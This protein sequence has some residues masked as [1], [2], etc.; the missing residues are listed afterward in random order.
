M[1]LKD[2]FNSRSKKRELSSKTLTSGDDPNK[3]RDGSFNMDDVFRKVYLLLILLRFYVTVL[4]MLRSKYKEFTVK[5][6][7]QK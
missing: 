6:K 4:R 3:I 2:Y 1:D 7:K 5:E